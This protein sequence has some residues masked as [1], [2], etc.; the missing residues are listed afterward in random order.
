MKKKSLG[1][2]FVVLISGITV[3]GQGGSTSV[4]TLDGVRGARYCEILVV[5][6]RFRK[7][8]ATVYNTFGK[9]DC[10]E[11]VWSSID[12][13]QLKED[14][15]ARAAVKNGPRYFMMDR[16]GAAVSGPRESKSFQGMEMYEVATVRVKKQSGPYNETTVNRTTVFVFKAGSVTYQLTGPKGSYVMQSYSQ[17]VD[18][19]L[20]EGD[21]ENLA[22]RLDLPRGWEFKVVRLEEDLVLNTVEEGKATVVQDDLRNTYQRID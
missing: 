15:D 12:T 3:F 10:P 19:D 20:A 4:P 2:L 13:D 1:L 5:K 8:K 16:I 7:L 18:K 11:E 9:N 6:G 17:I 21:L 14:L 22:D